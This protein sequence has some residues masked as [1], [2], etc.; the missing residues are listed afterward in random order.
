MMR[1]RLRASRLSAVLLCVGLLAVPV[2]SIV[3]ASAVPLATAAGECPAAGGVAVPEAP[4]AT[5]GALIA[6]G[7]GWG[8]SLGLSQYGALGAARLGWL[9]LG[10]SEQDVCVAPSITDVFTPN[11]SERALLAPRYQ[12]FK[13]LYHPLS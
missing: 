13:A 6:S 1:Y 12:R 10:G 5:T 2:A 3:P 7:H 11:A 8:H 4:L 9:A